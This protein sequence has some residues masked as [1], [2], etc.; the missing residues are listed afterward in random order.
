M[1]A[2]VQGKVGVGVAMKDRVQ[3]RVKLRAATERALTLIITL[4]TIGMAVT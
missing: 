3:A 2:S 4:M 1:R